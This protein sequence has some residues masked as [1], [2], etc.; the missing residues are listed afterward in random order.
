MDGHLP[1]LGGSLANQRMV[2][3]NPKDG[4]PILPCLAP[5]APVWHHIAW[6]AHTQTWK[7][8]R[9]RGH[10]PRKFLRIVEIFWLWKIMHLYFQK[11]TYFLWKCLMKH[12]I[13]GIFTAYRWWFPHNSSY[14]EKFRDMFFGEIFIV[15]KTRLRKDL[16]FF[17]VCPSHRWVRTPSNRVASQ[18]ILVLQISRVQRLQPRLPAC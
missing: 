2:T 13:F 16:I 9:T 10:C 11:K 1:S 12:L 4:Y 17:H 8:A 5:F 18:Q 3:H 7:K 14:C 6:V 15:D